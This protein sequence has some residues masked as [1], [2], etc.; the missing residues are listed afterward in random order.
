MIPNETLA[1]VLANS[2][3]ELTRNMWL[4]RWGSEPVPH[5]RIS[6]EGPAALRYAALKHKL[7]WY[8]FN[9]DAYAL[10]KDA[11]N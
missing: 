8:D 1:D 6:E 2:P 9:A 10:K 7:V 11:N 3:P 5:E 4:A